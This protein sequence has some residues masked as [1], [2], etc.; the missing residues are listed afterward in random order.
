MSG[1]G[2][3]AFLIEPRW[4]L[5]FATGSPVLGSHAVSV[6]G[7]RIQAVGPVAEM[8]QRYPAAARVVRGHHA[9][10]PGLVAAHTNACHT[11]LRGIPLRGP[12][13]RWLRETLAPIERRALSADLVRDGTRLG[14]AEML[15]AGITCYADDSPLPAEAAR[16]AAA[17]QVRALIGL[18]VSDGADAW[19]EDT[20]AHFASA[21][22]LWDEYRSDARIGLY[23]A[24]KPAR[25]LSDTTLTRLRR[26]ADE[27]DAR[28]VVHLDELGDSPEGA[29]G[30][31]DG[32]AWPRQ[33]AAH[34]RLAH[35]HQLGLLRP[36][37]AAIGALACHAEDAQLLSRHGAA[38]I[39]CPQAELRLLRGAHALP[40]SRPAALG[41]DTPAAAGALDVLAEARSAALLLGLAP[42]EALR[43]AT[44]GGATTLGVAAET[45]SIEPGKSADLTCIDLD[46]A[47]C[48]PVTDV[49][50]TILFGATRAQVSDV[51]SAGRAVVSEARLRLFD[52]SELAALAARWAER[53]AL[54]AAA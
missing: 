43:L 28:V 36:G 37:F 20:N 29:G 9:L 40:L 25:G 24:P 3:A 23:F 12:R 19:A 26:L 15:R 51:W 1:T 7:G 53:L 22:A 45:G 27:L 14:V 54:E 8:R 31:A 5:P 38:L 32:A 41:T 42:L 4:L 33:S 11:L 2:D 6:S 34:R 30:I 47:G 48:R 18:P 46:A 39:A 10:L 52:E 16:V 13:A 49:A 50:A 44:L 17:S 35:L 21:E